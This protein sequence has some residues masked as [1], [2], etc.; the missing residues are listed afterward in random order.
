MKKTTPERFCRSEIVALLARYDGLRLLPSIGTTT[1]IAGTLTFRAEGRT[2]PSIEDSYD[3]RLE[4]PQDFPERMA[5]AWE[6]G[7]RIPETHHKLDNAAL[8]LG[9]RIRL[10]LQT[11][12]S[13]SILR[14]VERCVIQYLYGYSHFSKTGAMPFGELHHG[15]LGSLQE[16]ASLLGMEMGPAIPYCVLATM[17]GAA[18]TSTPVRAAVDG[19]SA[20]ATTE[21]STHFATVSDAWFFG[22]RCRLSWRRSARRPRRRAQPHPSTRPETLRAGAM[23]FVKSRVD[24]FYRRGRCPGVSPTTSGSIDGVGGDFSRLKSM[25]CRWWPRFVPD[26]TACSLGSNWL[27]CSRTPHNPPR[28]TI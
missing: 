27:E 18:R 20:V 1:R 28:S 5:L 13:P 8:C 4:V 15:E 11:A 21:R 23:R 3:V 2:T 19:V 14:F 9:S 17:R 24:R 12:G 7:G 6:T 22:K 10:R 25:T 26:G 16:L